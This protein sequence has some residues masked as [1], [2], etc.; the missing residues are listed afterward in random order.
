MGAKELNMPRLATTL[1]EFDIEN[2]SHKK[3]SIDELEINSEE[4]NKIIWIHCDLNDLETLQKIVKK[5]KLTDDVIQLF[6]Q[7][8]PMPKI[9]DT[10]D[11]MTIQIPCLISN[12]INTTLIEQQ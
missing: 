7:E 6:D 11:A 1:I 3:I 12:E 4:K 5:I 8:D 2:R 9:I 10:D